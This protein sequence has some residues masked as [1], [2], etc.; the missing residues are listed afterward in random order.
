M[1]NPKIDAAIET[2]RSHIK[3]VELDST[4][5]LTFCGEQVKRLT[6]QRKLDNMDT[7][8]RIH[9]MQE[10]LEYTFTERIHELAT[11]GEE[12]E[13]TEL[14]HDARSLCEEWGSL[15][16]LE[17]HIEGDNPRKYLEWH[18]QAEMSHK[19]KQK[20]SIRRLYGSES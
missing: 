13:D 19:L 2:F 17:D 11:D 5:S 8:S 15:V 7:E 12:N 1:D 18:T 16:G 9:L 14:L 3:D 10:D 20:E 6:H 4:P